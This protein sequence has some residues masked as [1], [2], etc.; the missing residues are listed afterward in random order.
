MHLKIYVET[1]FAVLF[2][3][4]R[5]SDNTRERMIAY[6]LQLMSHKV[7]ITILIDVTEGIDEVIYLIFANKHF[8]ILFELETAS[9]LQQAAENN[10]RVLQFNISD[11]V[12]AYPDVLAGDCKRH[13]MM[14]YQHIES[15]QLWFQQ[16]ENHH[17][18]NVIKSFLIKT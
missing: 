11:V 5:P 2:R 9:F 10:I 4:F 13:R 3:L 7:H 18:E 8:C 1:D 14:E 17:F 12:S 6:A 15:M 16:P